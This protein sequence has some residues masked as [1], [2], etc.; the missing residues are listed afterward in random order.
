MLRSSG[1]LLLVLAVIAPLGERARAEPA[2]TAVAPATPQSP[3][4]TIGPT[5]GGPAAPLIEFKSQPKLVG[6]NEVQSPPPIEFG[7]AL[8]RLPP[9][10]PSTVPS[11]NFGIVPTHSGI[12]APLTP[13]LPPPS[14]PPPVA[15][16]EVP[17]LSSPQSPTIAF[18]DQAAGLV[19]QPNP[20]DSIGATTALP[21]GA[22]AS[23]PREGPPAVAGTNLEDL[24]LNED[25]YPPLP[26]DNMPAAALTLAEAVRLG[27]E[28][29]KNVVVLSYFPSI[30]ATNIATQ[31]AAYDPVLG[32]NAYGGQSDR[33]VRSLIDTFGA[34]SDI[35][36][37]DFLDPFQRQNGLYLRRK[38]YSGGELQM[39]FSTD[40]KDYFPPGTALIV[41]PGWDSA[42]NFRLDQPLFRDRG[43][44]V[45]TAPIRIAQASYDRSRYAFMAEVRELTANIEFAYW[46]LA[47]AERHFAVLDEFVRRSKKRLED[48]EE[49]RRLGQSAL[50]NVL[51]TRDLVEEFEVLA[52]KQRIERD[53][54]ESKLRQILGIPVEGSTSALLGGTANGLSQ[55]KLMA[56]D[57]APDTALNQPWESLVQM[58]QQRPE[59]LA[60]QSVVRA[61]RIDNGLARNALRPDVSARADYSV[62]GLEETLGDSIGTIGRHEFNTWAVGLI[63][64]RP[65]GLRA[66]RANLR[67][68]DLTLAQESARLERVQHDILHALRRAE[69]KA[70]STDALMAVV[71]RHAET[72]QAEFE[73]LEALYRE[74][75]VDIFVLLESERGLAAARADLVQ[76]WTDRQLAIA[77]RNYEANLPSPAYRIEIEAGAETT[78]EALP[79]E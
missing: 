37:T 19:S 24:S 50:P 54:A 57:E 75:R 69:E 49:R 35:L 76:A 17:V 11:L 33:Q 29:N 71:A 2:A 1:L 66:E 51:Q 63:Y 74:N 67:R 55:A 18:G 28:R 9:T 52:G 61:A 43:V 26:N 70:R 48:E 68:A 25:I 39:G 31:T 56:T 65:L 5:A 3:V 53:V 58:S 60:Q 40:Y 15:A 8:K 34:V 13:Q 21:A 23:P 7:G 79:A 78:E 14:Q 46:E 59:L 4:S 77:E 10:V 12:A 20:Q 45:A 42:V 30:N 16:A 72:A 73:A 22:P 64:E 44:D 6:D 47:G 27:L 41:N 32:A 36:Q 62:H 38:L